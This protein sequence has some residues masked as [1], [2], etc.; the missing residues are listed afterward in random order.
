MSGEGVQ[1]MKTEKISIFEILTEYAV[2]EGMDED[3]LENEDYRKAQSAIKDL[4][5]QLDGQGFTQEQRHMIDRFACAYNE[6][7]AC[8]GRI[9]YQKGF[10]DCVQLLRETGLLGLS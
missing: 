6:S 10:R 3:V 9:A 7:G 4:S 5:E 8:Y 1:N 2:N